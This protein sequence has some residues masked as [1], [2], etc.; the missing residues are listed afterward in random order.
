MILSK[1]ILNEHTGSYFSTYF[2]ENSEE[3]QNGRKRGVVIICPG[4]GYSFTSDREA[5]P[6]A[7]A[8]LS[9]GY[10]AVVLRY[11]VGE[12]AKMPTPLIELATTIGYIR[13]NAQEYYIDT[14]QIY[15]CGF[16]AGGHLAASLGVF[17]KNQEVLGDLA[18]DPQRIRPNG[19]IL[20]YPV[21]DLTSSTKRLDIG[22]VGQPE[23]ETIEFG[24]VHPNIERKDIFVREDGRTFIDF[25]VAMN[26]Y[27]F[28]G[29]YTKEQ[30]V[31]YSLQ[32]HVTSD[33]PPSF[34]WHSAKDNLILPQNSLRFATALDTHL[35]PY[36]LHIFNEGG[37]GLGLANDVTANHEW[38]IQPQCEPW[39]LMA[40]TWMK[41]LKG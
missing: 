26:A 5:E 16:S 36:E 2:I 40:V 37:H 18:K 20:G 9:K 15:V 32:N 33:T 39:F 12:A 35:V 1:S 19:L 24:Q 10:H 3:L 4:G 38:E 31:F 23:F 11:S 30:E 41:S 6:M 27:I 14:E 21:I 28:G 29:Y 22:I 7:L 17:Y 13:D 8:F 25:E 34:I